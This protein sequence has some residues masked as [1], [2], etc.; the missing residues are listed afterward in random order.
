[1]T[2]QEFKEAVIRYAREYGIA[3]YELYYTESESTSVEIYQEEVKGYSTE[4][5][6][7]VCFRC[8]LDGK[9]GYASTEN[10]TEEEAK[11]LVL[12]ALDNA[13]SIESEEKAFIH[14]KGDR[15]ST[16]E[17]TRMAQPT[18]GELTDA[19]L[20]L[21][22]ELYRADARVTDGTQA[23]MAYEAVI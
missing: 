13:G 8:V 10:R 7:G 19:A 15:Y 4:N 1:M 22:R 9:A 14:E 6:M 20:A 3:D 23:Y 2:Y 11:S 21:Q 18:G 17:E 12:R 5:S 16:P